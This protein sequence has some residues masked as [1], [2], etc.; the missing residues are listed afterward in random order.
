MNPLPPVPRPLPEP[1]Q[2]PRVRDLVL[3]YEGMHALVAELVLPGN[4]SM[5]VMSATETSRELI[6]HSSSRY[7]FATAAVTHRA[8]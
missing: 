2:D 6:R 1:A 3:D 5:Y 8:R 4:A 7:E